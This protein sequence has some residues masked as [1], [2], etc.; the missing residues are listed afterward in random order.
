MLHCERQEGNEKFSLFPHCP[1]T[2]I[3]VFCLCLLSLS[4]PLLQPLGG[5]AIATTTKVIVIA[6]F[7]EKKQHTSP[8]CNENV[9]VLAK[10]FKEKLK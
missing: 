1:V 5:I 8:G 9:A 4:C 2:V 6:T 3:A 10:Y 7:D